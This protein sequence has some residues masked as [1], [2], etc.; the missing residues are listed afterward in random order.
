MVCKLILSAIVKLGR[1]C[2]PVDV[3]YCGQFV[4]FGGHSSSLGNAE[5]RNPFI[6]D[7]F[8]CISLSGNSCLKYAE[9]LLHA[10]TTITAL[11]LLE[12]AC[13]FF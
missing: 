4:C 9:A 1:S 10:L 6:I 13:L 5:T 2:T 12:I 8:C 3:G 11:N 7:V